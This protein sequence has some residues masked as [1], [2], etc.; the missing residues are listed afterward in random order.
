M[1][2]LILFHDS[3]GQ[4]GALAEPLLRRLPR[5]VRVLGLERRFYPGSPRS[6]EALVEA[7]LAKVRHYQACGPWH[8]AGWSMG[9][10]LAFEAA[11]QL[12]AQDQ[13]V[14]L[15]G[16]IDSPPPS[17]STCQ[18]L[19]DESVVGLGRLVA[20]TDGD[21]QELSA[22]INQV[23]TLSHPFETVARALPA[24]VSEAVPPAERQHPVRCAGALGTIL[25]HLNLLAHY[26][27]PAPACLARVECFQAA[28]SEGGR[29]Q[30]WTPWIVGSLASYELAGDH[31]SILQVPAV[32]TIAGVFNHALHGQN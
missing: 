11:R 16:L 9:G 17:A 19:Y 30:G 10:T 2:N 7:Y 28:N 21:D 13:E 22:L 31:R 25:G 3:S 5:H 1:K 8:L 32:E 27:P 4:V 14:A 29:I 20:V 12:A 6:L 15:L 18:R 23:A 24:S 26:S